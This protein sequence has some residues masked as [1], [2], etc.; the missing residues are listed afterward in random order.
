MTQITTI[1]G[2]MM[3]AARPAAEPGVWEALMAGSQAGDRR[4][5]DRLLREVTPLL[6]AIARRRIH[7][8]AEAEDAVQDALLSIHALRHTYDPTRPLR[9][10]IAAI[11]ERRCIDRLRWLGRHAGDRVVAEDAE[12]IADPRQDHH[13]ERAVA[14]SQLRALVAMLPPVQRTAIALTKL[15]DL[16]LTEASARS[17][18]S[19]GALKVATFRAVRTMRARLLLG[20]D[21]DAHPVSAA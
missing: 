2:T 15:E 5:Y 12:Q 16:S 6:R 11:A 19:V 21:G 10:W 7:N 14:G 20:P 1:T 18:I 13:G 3:R 17:G 9:P 8:G 4:A